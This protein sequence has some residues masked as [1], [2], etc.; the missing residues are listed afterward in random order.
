VREVVVETPRV[1]TFV[2]D[3]PGW[4]GHLPGQHVELRL[5]GDD[6]SQ[7]HRVYS[8]AS[9]PE[10]TRV[11]LTIEHIEQGEVSPYLVGDVRPGDR[12][13]LRGPFGRFFVWTVADGGPLFLIAGGTGLVPLMAMLRHRAAAGSRVP[14]VLLYSSRTFDDIIYRDELD[15]L[16]ARGDGL[17]VVHTLTR[18]QPAGWSGGTQ[19]IDAG[20]LVRSGFPPTERPHVYICGP[21]SLVES[22]ARLLVALGHEAGRIK[23][24]RFGPTGV[25]R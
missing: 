18:G 23:T 11:S 7:A 15:S 16:A 22:A 17:A 1:R 12:F 9:A 2:L 19:R 24:E 20:M 3:V 13:E 14:A 8:I 4:P 21:T 6:G 25:E 10:S 5:T